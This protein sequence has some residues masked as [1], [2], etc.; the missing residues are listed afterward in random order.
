[1]KLKKG[2]KKGLKLIAIYSVAMICVLL[3][4][5]RVERLNEIEK[6]ESEVMAVVNFNK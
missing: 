1:M 4:A 2:I 6:L 3:M 5:E